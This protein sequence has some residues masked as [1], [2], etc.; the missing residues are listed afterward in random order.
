MAGTTNEFDAARASPGDVDDGVQLCART[1][2][3][4][5]HGGIFLCKA[6]VQLD[7]RAIGN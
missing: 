7:Q 4:G 3:I 1:N 6:L 2:L 5:E